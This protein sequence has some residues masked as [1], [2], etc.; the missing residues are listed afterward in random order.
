[1]SLPPRQRAL[2][3]SQS[4][5]RA[6]GGSGERLAARTLSQGW[7]RN[8]RYL[9][10]GPKLNQPWLFIGRTDAEAE[11]PILWPPDTKNWL[12]AKDP[13]AGKDWRWGN[14]G[15]DGWM[16]SLTQWTWVWANSRRWRR[17]GKAGVLQSMGSQRVGHD[18]VTQQQPGSYPKWCFLFFTAPAPH[19]K[20]L[21]K[22]TPT[23]VQPWAPRNSHIHV[24]INLK[25]I[26]V[27]CSK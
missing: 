20:E 13:D 18:L 5:H 1:M 25:L 7:A 14:R 11:A 16:A 3:Q 10:V 23:S 17:T 22:C 19:L 15:W 4:P 8:F 24:L 21:T 2:Q 9:P 26:F 27:Y 6:R 12:I